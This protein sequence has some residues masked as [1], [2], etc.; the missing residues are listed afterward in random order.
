MRSRASV[1]GGVGLSQTSVLAGE[2]KLYWR[3]CFTQGV[4]SIDRGQSLHMVQLCAHLS[5]SFNKFP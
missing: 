2:D 1:R 3:L 5:H 4:P